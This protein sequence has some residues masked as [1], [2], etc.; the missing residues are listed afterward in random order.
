[1]TIDKDPAEI[2]GSTWKGGEPMTADALRRLAAKGPWQLTNERLAAAAALERAAAE[3]ARM[4]ER[5]DEAPVA[6]EVG[7][8]M[9]QLPVREEP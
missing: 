6:I 7:Q 5:P 2:K 3:I 1:M 8:V 4:A 9:P